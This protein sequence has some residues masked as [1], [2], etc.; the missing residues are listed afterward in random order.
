MKDWRAL[1]GA[2]HAIL[3][4]SQNYFL[5][6]PCSVTRLHA[7]L[8]TRYLQSE[9]APSIW[10]PTQRH[11]QT[12]ARASL[13][14]HIDCRTMAAKNL[15][16]RRLVDQSHAK[17]CWICYKL[18]A[19]VLI[20]PDNDDW[21]HI[22]PSHLTDRNFATAKDAE[23]LQKKKREQDL[24]AEIEAVK[25]E[26]AEKQQKRLEK[27]KSKDAKKDQSKTEE[28]AQDEQD[29]KEKQ[30]KLNALQKTKDAEQNA[31]DGPRVFEL[32][33]KFFDMRM[34]KKRDA[35]NA[36]RDRARLKNPNTFPSVPTGDP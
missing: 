5:H 21:F 33:R 28:K 27:R 13:A 30:E 31:N 36:K 11:E 20:T 14:A 7:S 2:E 3:G 24:E 26:Y 18:S 23:H 17:S 29:E 19:V 35:E 4:K 10:L 6:Q 12:D 16:H 1:Q 9:F 34:Q 15:Y 8:S 32:H 25:K 22:C